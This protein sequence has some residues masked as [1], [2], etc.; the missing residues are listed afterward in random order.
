MRETQLCTREND[1]LL[2]W[3]A[4]MTFEPQGVFLTLQWRSEHD[5]VFTLQFITITWSVADP[6]LETTILDALYLLFDTWPLREMNASPSPSESSSGRRRVACIIMKNPE[7]TL[8]GKQ[9]ENHL[10]GFP[11][12][13]PGRGSA[14]LELP[15]LLIL[16]SGFPRVHGNSSPGRTCPVFS[17]FQCVKKNTKR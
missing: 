8:E 17:V 7:G 9:P 4:D 16:L 11:G 1:K 3:R 15:A 12:Y 2:L 13:L 14:G 6:G 10:W 5:S